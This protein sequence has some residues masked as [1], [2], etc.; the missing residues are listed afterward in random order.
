MRCPHDHRGA[1]LL[2]GPSLTVGNQHARR[3]GC[4]EHIPPAA[5]PR[6]QLIGSFEPSSRLKGIGR[7][8][9]L[10]LFNAATIVEPDPFKE[11]VCDLA[12]EIVNLHGQII[13]CVPI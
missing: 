5:A 7:C 11:V 10:M 13:D 2:R 9:S 8:G 3:T 6:R 12:T 1:R 4:G